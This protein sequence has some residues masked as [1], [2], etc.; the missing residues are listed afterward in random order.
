MSLLSRFR[1]STSNVSLLSDFS[2]RR[3]KRLECTR[4]L[5]R[6]DPGRSNLLD[7]LAVAIDRAEADR[8]AVLW[9]DECGPALVHVHCVLDLVSDAPR[10]AFAFQDCYSSWHSGVPGFVDIPRVG[11]GRDAS[12]AG[13]AR[14]RCWVSMGSDGTRA[15]FLTVDS[16]TP[17]AE[18]SVEAVEELMFLAGEAAAVVLHRDLDQQPLKVQSVHGPGN[19]SECEG[20]SGWM[21]LKDLERREGDAQLDQRIATRFLVGRAVRAVLDEEWAMDSK[22][23]RQLVDRVEWEFEVLDRKDLERVEWGTVLRTLDA[24]D[25]EAL[26][27]SLLALADCLDLQGHLY[28]TCEF[29]NL[30]YQVAIACGSGSIAGESARFLGKTHRRLGSWKE[31]ANWYEVAMDMGDVFEDD[32]LSALALGGFGHTL[33]EKGNLRDAFEAHRRSLEWAKTLGDP[34]VQGFAHH[35][36]MTDE[37]LAGQM[38]AAIK[39]GWEAVQLYPTEPDRL[40]ALTDLAWVFVEGGDLGA[41]ED[42][43]TV[44]AHRSEDFVY[45][46]YAL[47]V[48]AYIEAL[49]GDEKSFNARLAT[50]DETSWRTGSPFMISELFLNRGKAYRALGDHDRAVEWLEQAKEF[51]KENGNNQVTFQAEAELESLRSSDPADAVTPD[52]RTP[53]TLEGVAGV[54]DG[55]SLLRQELSLV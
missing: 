10:R 3:V 43:Y 53:T 22:A 44:V 13:G 34:Y 7:H 23:L 40:R 15:W 24:G 46:V 48:L 37:K 20:F 35:N 47:A 16:V 28:G 32:R 30:A 54:R 4:A 2:E 17:R 1:M 8:A 21:I 51:S 18:L 36:L 29:L 38:S 25:H 14:S 27:R 52:L 12:F 45:R 39:H 41:A 6:G 26:G 5:F 31:S 9:L 49:R 19:R 50:L 42:A 55:L 11:R 33:R